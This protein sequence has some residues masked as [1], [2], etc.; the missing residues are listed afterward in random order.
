M[1][2]IL[3]KIVANKRTEI[4]K[5]E[6]Q[7]PLEELKQSPLYGREGLSMRQRLQDS[8]SGIISEFKRKSPSKGFIKEGARVADIVPGYEQNGASGISVLADSDFFGGSPADVAQARALVK[9]TPILFKEFLFTSYQLHLAKASGADV[10][11]LIAS[12]MTK[13]TCHRLALEARDLGLET[14]LELYEPEEADYIFDGVSMVGI[15][16][17]NLKTFE[18]NL[19]ESIRLCHCIPDQYV[20]VSESGISAPE[21]VKMLREEGFRGF[22]M[23]ENF[24]KQDNPA[25]ALGQFISQVNG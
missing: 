24:M 5:A 20:K 21:T 8:T 19:E 11:L 7:H 2:T 6:K 25:S 22:L 10:V 16:N 18:V 17:R 3:D 14:L 9:N 13:E 4:A 12:I 1:T 15:N 23:G